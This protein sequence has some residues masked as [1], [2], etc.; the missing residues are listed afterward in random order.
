MNKLIR[1][2]LLI[3]FDK[4]GIT[5]SARRIKDDNILLSELK[6]KL[7]EEAKEVHGS[8]NHKDLLEELADVMEVITAIMK[9]EKISQK[10]IKTAALDKNKVK[11][12]FLK[13]RLFCEYVDI[14]EENPAI[15]YYLNNEKY[16]I[17]L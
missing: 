15:K 8:S 7:I 16:S 17:R 13:E 11:G 12:D 5:Y 6:N 10:E 4:L 1:G 14:A 9:I 3:L 2:K